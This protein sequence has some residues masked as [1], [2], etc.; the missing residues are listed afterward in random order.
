MKSL[1]YRR[2]PGKAGQNFIPA[3]RDH[4]ITT[5]VQDANKKVLANTEWLE[6]L[7][8]SIINPK[9]YFRSSWIN[10]ILHVVTQ[11]EEQ[12]EEQMFFLA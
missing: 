12:K 4:V 1:L 5:I 3:N 7:R 11:I 9:T 6:V 2:D 10:P 8:G